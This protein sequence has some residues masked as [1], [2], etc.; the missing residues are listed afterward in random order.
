MGSSLD[1]RYWTCKACFR[2]FD[3]EA[4]E[5]SNNHPSNHDQDAC[6]KR[7]TEE[8]KFRNQKWPNSKV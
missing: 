4:S 3:W 6:E 2:Q 5:N 1:S 7:A 8:E